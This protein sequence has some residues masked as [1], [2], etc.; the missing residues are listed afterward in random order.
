MTLDGGQEIIRIQDYFAFS[1]DGENANELV[2]DSG[3][4]LA[5]Y[6]F[7]E[8]EL[9]EEELLAGE[10]QNGILLSSTVEPVAD[11]D[12]LLVGESD[13]LVSSL[14]NWLG[15]LSPT[16]WGIGLGGILLAG[17]AAVALMDDDD[18]S[19]HLEKDDSSPDTPTTPAPVTLDA[20]MD[21]QGDNKGALK[22]GDRTDD[23]TP[24]FKGTGE[25]GA[26]I[27]INDSDGE[28]LASTQV[29]ED[30]T[31]SVSL[32]T[33]EDGDH[34]YQVVQ[35]VGEDVQQG[36][37]ISLTIGEDAI[38]PDSSSDPV[39]AID[40]VSDDDVV[41][42]NELEDGISI[43][44]SAEGVD[45]GSTMIITLNGKSYNTELNTDGSWEIELPGETLTNLSAG[46]HELMLTVVDDA[47][48]S[49][50][51]Q[52]TLLIESDTL[53][54][55]ASS[56]ELSIDLSELLDNSST[57]SH[58]VIDAGHDPGHDAIS[59]QSSSF[60][61]AALLEGASLPLM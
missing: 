46:E 15:S 8:T 33:Q 18:D 32:P 26:S 53:A 54:M 60:D 2:L 61:M 45:A 48:E 20:V 9:T 39:L 38:D 6:S 24:T 21:D 30:G 55:S 57:A 22:D 41:G 28:T 37:S 50:S 5:K 11:I 52:R 16:A 13:S 58:S 43:S 35:I 1:S 47:G 23:H 34:Q 29:A 51:I 12:E 40:P 17:G 4:Q 10:N 19:N 3:D 27:Q 14:G 44:G 59:A 42:T 36:D 7:S 56:E 49:H 31:W 25:P